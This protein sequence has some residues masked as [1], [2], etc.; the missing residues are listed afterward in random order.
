MLVHEM[1]GES[2]VCWCVGGLG[3]CLLD[4]YCIWFS[5][6]CLMGALWE[7]LV[8]SVA[9]LIVLDNLDWDVYEK[10]F[11]LHGSFWLLAH[12]VSLSCLGSLFFFTSFVS[13]P[14]CLE[15]DSEE[16]L[17]RTKSKEGGRSVVRTSLFC[18]KLIR[19]AVDG[20]LSDFVQRSFPHW[21][22]QIRPWEGKAVDRPMPA[23]IVHGFSSR[24]VLLKLIHMKARHEVFEAFLT[25]PSPRTRELPIP[26]KRS[27]VLFFK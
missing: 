20:L 5:A 15:R 24:T 13:T 4:D 22:S 7:Y 26:L 1:G 11:M 16:L 17:G 8:G 6:H 14:R 9:C 10:R 2:E 19:P 27:H 21:S 25:E 3:K 12:C 23:K 18:R